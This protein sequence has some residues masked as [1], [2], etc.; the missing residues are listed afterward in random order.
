[1]KAENQRNILALAIAQA[2]LG[3]QMPMYII[4]GGLV[5]QSLAS[6][7]CYATIPISLLIVGSILTIVLFLPKGPRWI[8]LTI[9]HQKLLEIIG[10]TKQ[11]Y[12][13]G[14]EKK[15]KQGCNIFWQ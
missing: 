5:G 9:F 3:S 6:N 13:G 7:V 10:N 2:I 1:M 12:Q 14:V 15:D 4:L 8:K 11:E